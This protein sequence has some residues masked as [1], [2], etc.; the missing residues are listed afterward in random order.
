MISDD[1][2]R[3]MLAGRRPVLR[4]SRGGFAS[5]HVSTCPQPSNRRCS[6][7]RRGSP[8]I[9]QHHD[10]TQIRVRAIDAHGRARGADP[11]LD[12]LPFGSS[13]G[14]APRSALTTR[15]DTSGQRF[16]RCPFPTG[17]ARVRRARAQRLADLARYDTRGMVHAS[18]GPT[19]PQL[20]GPHS[21]AFPGSL[22]AWIGKRTIRRGEPE[23]DRIPLLENCTVCQKSVSHRREAMQRPS[24]G[25]AS[26]TERAGSIPL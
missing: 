11:G 4:N 8:Y 19:S 7:H 24:S 26:C 22:L 17:N 18:A 14:S 16:V 6:G 12:A 13:Q 1:P 2:G 5:W 15:L 9:A 20:S 25:C 10:T 3:D 23:R 21:E